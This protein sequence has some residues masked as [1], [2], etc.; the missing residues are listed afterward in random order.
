MRRRSLCA[1]SLTVIL[2]LLL[3]ALPTQTTLAQEQ[4]GPPP[5]LPLP[6]SD[7]A[8]TPLPPPPQPITVPPVA[9]AQLPSLS[10][11]VQSEP[12]WAATGDLVTTTLTVS[13]QAPY[14][15]DDLVLTLPLPA[16]ARPV[17]TALFSAGG[18]QQW[19]LPTLPPGAQTVLTTTLRLERV[20]PGEALL[21]QPSA[22]A[23]GLTTPIT[24]TG[25]VLVT[26]TLIT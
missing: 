23:H 15:A 7:T 18:A 12:L 6:P 22:I 10:L 25:G 9:D 1:L 4:V 5:L 13:N 24:A 21:L 19:K 8:T 3:Q 16:E 2:S 20:P 14:P 11:R 17:S 26:T